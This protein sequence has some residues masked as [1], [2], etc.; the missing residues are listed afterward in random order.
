MFLSQAIDLPNIE[1]HKI[2]SMKL[3]DIEEK[4]QAGELKI[5]LKNLGGYV[6]E[7]LPEESELRMTVISLVAQN[8]RLIQK[9]AAKILSDGEA[10]I[11][12]NQIRFG[13]LEI[14]GVLREEAHPNGTYED[15]NSEIKGKSLILFFSA[16]PQD[17]SP[18]QLGK[19]AREI[20]A[21]LKKASLSNR[22]EFKIAPATRPKD[23]L[24]T[25]LEHQ[26]EF[27]HFSGH[28]ESEGIFMLDDEGDSLFFS[29]EKLA[30]VFK[31]FGEVVGCVFLNACYS[32]DQSEAMRKYIPHIVGTTSA[33]DDDD[34]SKFAV[35]F[36]SAIAEGREIPFAFE[37]AKLGVD[38]DYGE[39]DAFVLN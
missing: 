10:S 14:I 1:V 4:L 21:A 5:G 3:H 38:L 26:P 39:N 16:N 18:L 13:A 8:N 6:K 20:E 37:L 30:D 2:I 11:S 22:F 9:R 17:E 36:Y 23:F 35:L 24:Q 29:K 28:G 7:K 12:E 34:A 19:E 15:Q 32:A 33:V 25:L 31:L 27:V